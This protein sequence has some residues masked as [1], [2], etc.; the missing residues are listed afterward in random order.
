[1]HSSAT[2]KAPWSLLWRVYPA[3]RACQQAHG[4]LH[5]LHLKSQLTLLKHTQPYSS[6]RPSS[7]KHGAHG[8]K[9]IHLEASGNVQEMSKLCQDNLSARLLD[10]PVTLCL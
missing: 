4:G 5:A 10:R 1:M 2:A 7:S 3:L 6:L 9:V 8:L